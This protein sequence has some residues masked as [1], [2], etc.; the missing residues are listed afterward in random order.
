MNRDTNSE[1][2]D[3]IAV[4]VLSKKGNHKN[5]KG[6]R[7]YSRRQHFTGGASHDNAV[8]RSNE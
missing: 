1:L 3:E 5:T 8:L 7:I 2:L 6:S 4:L